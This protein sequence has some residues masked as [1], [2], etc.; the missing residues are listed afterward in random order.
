MSR[1]EES[2]LTSE[3]IKRTS[4]EFRF[5]SRDTFPY[6]SKH[7]AET[8]CLSGLRGSSEHRHEVNRSWLTGPGLS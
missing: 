1:L 4:G 5:G 6:Q 2:K 8:S 3:K 7:A